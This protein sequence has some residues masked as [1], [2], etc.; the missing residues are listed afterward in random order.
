MEPTGSSRSEHT[1]RR[2]FNHEVPPWIDPDMSDYFITICC[3]QRGINQLCLPD[4][5]PALL[6]SAR[7][8]MEQGKWFPFVFLLMPDHLHMIVAFGFQHRIKTIVEGW[9]RYAATRHRVVWQRGFF[10]HRLRGDEGFEEKAAYIRQNPVRAGLV[11]EAGEWPL[12]FTGASQQ[13]I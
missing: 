6:E 10:E 4:I 11:Q 7:F 9:K 8:Y 5:G 3:K 12:C 1:G 13:R 2:V